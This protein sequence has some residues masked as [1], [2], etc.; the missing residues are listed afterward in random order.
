VY[1]IN[2]FLSLTGSI[3][4]LI[5]VASESG[6]SLETGIEEGPANHDYSHCVL[7]AFKSYDTFLS[8]NRVLNIDAKNDI[9]S[10]H[11]LTHY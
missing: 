10:W 9:V 7:V 11:L 8:S 2:P 1:L 5:P 3:F 4:S 6:G